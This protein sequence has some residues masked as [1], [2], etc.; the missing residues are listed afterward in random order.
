MY[1]VQC[2]WYITSIVQRMIRDIVTT[3]TETERE[4]RLE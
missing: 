2:A 1:S 4:A 3:Y